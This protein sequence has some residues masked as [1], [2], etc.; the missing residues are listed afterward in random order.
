[1]DEI[2]NRCDGLRLSMKEE[3]EDEVLSSTGEG[4]QILVGKFYMKRRVGVGG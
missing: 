3:A 2:T 1:M 4:R